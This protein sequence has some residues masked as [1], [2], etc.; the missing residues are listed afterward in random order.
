MRFSEGLARKAGLTP[1]QHQ[2]LLAIRGSRN[3]W[4]TVGE[5]AHALIIRPHSAVGLVNRA[6]RDGL[7]NKEQDT[8]DLRRV[9]V[10]LTERGQALIADLT[11]AHR[12]ELMR[13]WKRIPTLR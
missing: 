10:H 3:G 11:A 6:Q 13:L 8:D 9:Q 4:M 12:V 2:L 1:V 7:V 5:V